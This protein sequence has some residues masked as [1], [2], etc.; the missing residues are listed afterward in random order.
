ME[1]IAEANREVSIID[2][3]YDFPTRGPMTG[4]AQGLYDP[5]FEHDACGT[6]FVARVSGSPS[7]DIVDFA[8]ECLVNLTHRGAVDADART[9]DGAGIL[10]PLPY[11]LFRREL[12][13]L[14]V[15]LDDPDDLAVGMVFLPRKDPQGNAHTRK[16]I[17]D[18]I[19]GEGLRVLGWREVPIRPEVLGE[20]ALATL[21]DIQQVFV[22]RRAGLAAGDF[23]RTIYLIRKKIEV[24]WLKIGITEAYFPSFSSQTIVYKG[25]FVAPQVR[26][27][28]RDLRDADYEVG[29]AV[30]HQRYSTN[31]F[32]NWRLAQPF[33]LLAHNGEINTRQGNGYWMHAREP[34]LRSPIWGDRIQELLPVI[35]PNGSDSSDLDNALELLTQSGRDVRHAL[36]LLMPHAWEHMADLDRQRRAFYEFSACL[37]EPWDGPAALAFTDGRIVG[38]ALDRNG[39]RPSRYLVTKDGLVV[40]GSEV[41]MLERIEVDDINVVEK[42]RLG[43]GHM[44]AV[45]TS[46]GEFFRNAQLKREL[47]S[48]QPYA[49]WVEQQIVRLKSTQKTAKVPLSADGQVP[50]PDLRLLRLFGFSRED[51]LYVFP[52]MTTEGKEAIFS[53]GDDT[54]I[55]PLNTTERSFY[56]YFR[57]RFAQVTN[58]PIDPLREHLVM[59]LDTYIGPRLSLLEETEEHARLIHLPSPVLTAAQFSELTSLTQECYRSVVLS[60]VFS[61]SGPGIEQRLEE[62]CSEAVAAVRGGA[63]LLV[64]S[65]REVGPDSVPIPIA[66]VVAAIHHHLIR[67]GLRMRAD[68]IVETGEA[69]DVHHFAVLIGYGTSAIFPYAAIECAQSFAGQRKFEEVTVDSAA[70]NFQK[71]VEAGLLKVMSKMGIST[72]SSYRGAQ[73]FEALG[74]SQEVVDR[75]FTGTP[76]L[77][78]GVGLRQIQEDVLI[79]HS[80]AFS[81]PPL[82]QLPDAGFIRFRR[83]GESH[84]YNPNVVR[85]IHKAAQ[86]GDR[87]AYRAA[88]DLMDAQPPTTVRDLL[89]FVSDRPSIPLAGVEAMESIRARFVSTAMSLGALS[90]EAYTTLARAMSMIG[91]RSNSGEGGEDP[92]WYH[93]LSDGP[94]MHSAIKQ[95]ASARF[96]VTA[97]YLSRAREIEI[98]MAQGSKP[99]E[100][101]QL[102]GHKV[103][104]LI[105]RLRH[106]VPGIQLISPPPHHDIYSIEDLAQLIYDLKQV[107][108]KARIGV[109]LVSEAGVGTIAAGVA[110]AYADYILISGHSG[111]TGASPLSSIKFAGSP[112]EIGL[113]ETQQILR[114]NDLRRRVRLRTDGG[115]RTGRD[116]V[117]A[118]LLGAEEF[119]FGTLAVVTIGCDMARQCH[120]NTC[121]TGIATQREDL[122]AKFAGKP[123][124]VINYFSLMAEEVREILAS[125]GYRSLDEIVGH[126]ELL[127]SKSLP[128]TARAASL[129]MQRVLAAHLTEQTGP[130]M[131]TQERNDREDTP[132][133][134]RILHDVEA[135][136]DGEGEVKLTYRIRNSNRTVGAKI[137]GQ[138]AYRYGA[139][140]L[141]DGTIDCTFVGSAGQSFGAFLTHGMRWCLIGQAN[142]YVAK[143][144]SGG[145]VIVRPSETALY[146]WHE[147]V[148][149]GNTLLYGATGGALF[150]AGRAGERFAVRNSGARAVVE[151]IGDHGCEYMT[152]GVVAV[153]GSVGRNFAAGMS[154]GIAF[155]LDL[156]GDFEA[157]VNKELAS[158]ARVESDDDAEILKDLIQEHYEATASPRANEILTHW[159]E[160]RGHF[161]RVTPRPYA[162]LLESGEVHIR[163]AAASSRRPS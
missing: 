100:G 27:F 4:K 57:Q 36:T 92:A 154:A 135:A 102:P 37:T 149:A 130:R 79:R 16:I 74:L 78:G 64:L 54:P 133:D 99:G 9:G 29:L 3:H 95:V 20:K 115:L 93:P 35:L 126:T 131:H 45:D 144:M 47:S 81:T 2:T 60:T 163:Q 26:Q 82:K 70:T 114:M 12:A 41:G 80:S 38:A 159:S 105:A 90:P 40:A 15:Q 127:R 30:F 31:T 55:L 77:I 44:I 1:T 21:P 22:G 89:E 116:V 134:D 6:G 11:T 76:S 25:L 19:R 61:V 152:G 118:A 83:E 32:P 51:L 50:T 85:A 33:R 66:L 62:L 124:H 63:Y 13:K 106:A 147:N 94:A 18:T 96:G 48:Q 71:A 160:Y 91:A 162:E 14:G 161:V 49:T 153:L 56:S 110:K 5:F 101:G 73:I 113:A 137:A 72:I 69:W 157:R 34:E 46:R 23:E 128:N 151:G 111:G 98:K 155:V 84:A 132:L 52:S 150:V 43:P 148:I 59:A 24:A 109:K 42:G 146:A 7:H 143:G 117:V 142:D 86:L 156:A 121:P 158:L 138:I 140:G 119:G 68:L 112:W 58:P 88:R 8:L 125:L 97:E 39:L 141:P 67:S 104:A 122:R 28:Y 108:P 17:E 107:N 123:E 65:D 145:E 139:R 75:Y 136:L 129:D 103:T 10:T 120:L 87:E 53:M